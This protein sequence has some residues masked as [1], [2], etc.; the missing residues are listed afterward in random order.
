VQDG[1][2]WHSNSIFPTLEITAYDQQ[3]ST[4]WMIGSKMLFTGKNNV[5][6]CAKWTNSCM[7]INCSNGEVVFM[8]FHELKIKTNQ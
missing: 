4:H 1:H 3:N 2:N 6:W 7:H 8:T 5:A